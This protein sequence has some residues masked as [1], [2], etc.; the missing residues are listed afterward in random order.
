M[1]KAGPLVEGEELRPDTKTQ[2]RT[3]SARWLHLLW[4]EGHRASPRPFTDCR[5]NTWDSS[6]CITDE[7][8]G[9]ILC[10][11][12]RTRSEPG[13]QGKS[14]YTVSNQ[15]GHTS[16]GSIAPMGV[17]RPPPWSRLHLDFAGPFRGQ[18]FLLMV[19]AHSKWI[20]AH[21]MSNITAPT[22]IDKLRQ[23]FA[24]C[25]LP[26]TLVTDNGMTFTSELF[27]E[28]MQQND[29][30]HIRTAPFHPAANGL[31][32]CAVQTVKEGLKRMTGDSQCSAF[33]VPV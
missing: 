6:R 16:T 29:I 31:A 23:V 11:V 9:K 12:A 17:A 4:S 19:D 14:M 7:K 22:S 26:D 18:M 25:G 8:P 3:E 5:G 15:S 10:L 1:D 28:F 13:E 27:G 24:V 2:N 33:T 20:E 30:H 21:I 32:E